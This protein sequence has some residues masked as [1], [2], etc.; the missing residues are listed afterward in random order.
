MLVFRRRDPRWGR[1][2]EAGAECP[3]LMSM[4]AASFSLGFQQG[5]TQAGAMPRHAFTD[6]AAAVASTG[7]LNGIATIKHWNGNTLEDSD[8]WTR[9]NFDDNV[10]D[11]V[12]ADNTF[13]AF[14]AGIR[15]GG[16]SGVM[17]AYN[18]VQGLPSCTSPLLKA[19]LQAWNFSGYHLHQSHIWIACCFK[20]ESTIVK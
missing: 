20:F 15:A 7:F 14:R 6:P 17:C 11:F 19:T 18:A 8:G 4:Y 3:Y 10:S 13:P 5:H 9:H 16:A 1:N 2:G 12:L